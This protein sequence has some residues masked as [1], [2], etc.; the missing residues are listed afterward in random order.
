M[1]KQ[2]LSINTNILYRGGVGRGIES[3]Q[4]CRYERSAISIVVELSTTPSIVVKRCIVVA[5]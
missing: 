2:D 3:C 1:L 5:L 4:L